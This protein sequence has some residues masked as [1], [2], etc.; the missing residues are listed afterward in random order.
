MYDQPSAGSVRCVPAPPPAS[1]REQFFGK[2]PEKRKVICHYCGYNADLIEDTVIF[3]SGRGDMIWYCQRDK[4]WAGV[5]RNSTD[6]A[7]IGRLADDH[8]RGLHL[9]AMHAFNNYWKR[10]AA[11]EHITAHKAR[12][13][14]SFGLV[15]AL[16]LTPNEQFRI[17][18]LG[19]E[20]AKRVIEICEKASA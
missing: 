20:Q 16:D 6:F 5:D 10:V 7:P 1:P 11:A 12:A 9:R 19:E 17:W 13:R 3:R 8:L 18:F 4:A 2:D 15:R 14:A